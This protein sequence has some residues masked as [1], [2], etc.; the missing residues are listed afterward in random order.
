M[1]KLLD[2]IFTKISAL[3]TNQEATKRAPTSCGPLRSLLHL[4]GKGLS[5]HKS[6]SHTQLRLLEEGAIEES[7]V[8][9]L[10][11]A[12]TSTPGE[13]ETRS[14]M[15]GLSDIQQIKQ[16]NSTQPSPSS[17]TYEPHIPEPSEASEDDE[18]PQP[19]LYPTSTRV[20]L[21]H[22]RVAFALTK[23]TID[24]LHQV[25]LNS[26]SLKHCQ[27][28]F[29]EAKRKAD[30]GQSY[31]DMA[32]SQIN[33]SKLPDHFREQVKQD[34]EQ[35]RAVILG[36][37]QRKV[38]LEQEL[39]IQSCNVELQRGDM[40][41]LFERIMLDAGIIE[42]AED[43]VSVQESQT[44][45]YVPQANIN[46]AEASDNPGNEVEIEGV[47]EIGDLLPEF[48][49]ASSDVQDELNAE[50]SEMDIAEREHTQSW[51]K[52]QEANLLF[53]DREEAY[54]QDLAE[55]LG[56]GEYSRRT[57]IDLFHCKQ[58]A[59]LTKNLQEAEEAFERTRARC[60]ALGIQ[61]NSTT[62]AGS[63]V[64][65]DDQGYRESQEPARDTGSIDRDIIE[66]WR[67]QIDGAEEPHGEEPSPS[68][69]DIWDAESVNIS[70]S[71]STR[72]HNP[73]M[74]KLITRWQKQ[75]DLLREVVSMDASA[76]EARAT[77]ASR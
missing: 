42:E 44:D 60:E 52:L 23:E 36:D 1:P 73:R 15:Y 33:N 11:D 34:L 35:C 37:I 55:H 72:A 12:H 50:E 26:R 8:S 48:K 29:E 16:V 30:V 69:A 9:I 56:T 45:R 21:V 70:D 58:G 77:L 61:V 6:R 10:V 24:D 41:D 62:A 20:V 32:E 71:C 17:E 57:E 31:I 76:E 3:L 64:F 63:E 47:T 7:Q 4:C 65:F 14:S 46:D 66:L 22:D 13:W 38:D 25:I 18:A 74:Q 53:E 43:N 2:K 67:A 68:T 28:E 5:L 19:L 39:R 49:E 40:D 54:K 51:K 59:T 75:Q 27:T